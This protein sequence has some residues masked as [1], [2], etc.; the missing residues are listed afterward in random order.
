MYINVEK[1]FNLAEVAMPDKKAKIDKIRH[2]VY[3]PFVCRGFSFKID[4]YVC[5]WDVK[6]E[7]FVQPSD[8]LNQYGTAHDIK[9]IIETFFYYLRAAE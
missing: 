4:E 1:I 8:I 3:F 2:N 9:N 7:M 6:I 5:T